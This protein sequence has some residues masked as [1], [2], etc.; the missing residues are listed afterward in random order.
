MFSGNQRF[1]MA[2]VDYNTKDDLDNKTTHVDTL[3]E[4]LK[5][6]ELTAF[7]WFVVLNKHLP[8]KELDNAKKIIK[9]KQKIEKLE[10][11]TAFKELKKI[12]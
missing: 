3:M 1:S 8:K 9:I 11:M 10:Y 6:D 4:N 12:K 7:K 5:C 2:L